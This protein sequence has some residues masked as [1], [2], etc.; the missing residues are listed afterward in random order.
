MCLL[1]V[2]VSGCSGNKVFIPGSAEEAFSYGMNK[3]HSGEYEDSIDAFQKVIFNYPG[4]ELIDQAIFYL[5]DSYYEEKDYLL[6][7]NEFERLNSEFPDGAFA[8]RALYKLGLCHDHLSLRYELDQKETRKAIDSFNRLVNRFPE[9]VYADSARVRMAGL[10]DKLA[11]K[12]FE[13]G[14]FYFKRKYYDSAVIYL[15]G[16]REEYPDRPWA[17]SSLYFLA[18]AYDELELHD[19]ADEAREDL[20]RLYPGSEE[21]RRLRDEYPALKDAKAPVGTVGEISE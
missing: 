8:V 5:A 7:A 9:S 1:V 18:K 6:A 15:E 10:Q 12:E 21:A 11:R 2:F 17:A 14:R 13:C 4:V 19:D 20:L 3:Y 16:L